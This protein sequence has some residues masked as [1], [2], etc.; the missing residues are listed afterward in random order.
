MN[1]LHVRT[2]AYMNNQRNDFWVITFTVS[3]KKERRQW[4]RFERS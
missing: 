2:V 1:T 4:A 3:S